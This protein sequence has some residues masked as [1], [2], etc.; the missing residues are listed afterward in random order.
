MLLLIIFFSCLL[1]FN[2]LSANT[3]FTKFVDPKIV[4]GTIVEDRSQF[5]YLVSVSSIKLVF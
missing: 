2:V 1:N 4:G 5:A 3:K